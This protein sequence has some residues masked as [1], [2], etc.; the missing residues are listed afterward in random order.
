MVNVVSLHSR[1]DFYYEYDQYDYQ[2]NREP[3][4]LSDEW[5]KTL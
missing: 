3:K 4:Y 5:M 1:T 2:R